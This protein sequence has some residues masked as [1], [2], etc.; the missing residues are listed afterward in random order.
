MIAFRDLPIKRKL[1]LIIML[2]IFVAL[3]CAFGAFVAYDSYTFRDALT[4]ELAGQAKELADNAV[5][6]AAANDTE[7][8]QLALNAVR[9]AAN[10]DSAC[11]YSQESRILAR[12]PRS[13]PDVA[14]PI[15]P[16]NIREYYDEYYFF[17]LQPI[18]RDQVRIGYVCL[19]ANYAAKVLARREQYIQIIVVVMLISSLVGFLVSSKLQGLIS[20]PIRELAFTARTISDKKDFSVRAVKRSGDEVG[21]LIDAFNT[22]LADI[23]ARDEQLRVSNEQ[24]EE[25]NRTLEQKVQKRTTE[26]ATAMQ[27]AESA[28]KAAEVANQTKS[29]F[30]A[31]MSHELRTPMNAI[32]GYSEML[33]EEAQDLGEESF[34][35]DLKKVHSAGTHLLGL[36][37]D[38]LDISKIESGKMEVYL[39]TFDVAQMIR[40]VASTVQPLLEKNTNTLKVECPSTIGT[41]H[42]DGTKI[43][44]GLFNLLSNACKFTDR[45]TITL[46]VARDTVEEKGWI[47]F[48]VSD[49]G[50]GLTPEQI[51]RLFQAFTQADAGTTKKYGGT[52]L[53][54]VI[55]RRFCQMMGG[56][57][58]VESEY[59]KGSTFV[60][61]IPCDVVTS[62]PEEPAVAAK[63]AEMAAELP[64]GATRILVI[65]DDPTVHDLMRRFLRKEG[66]RVETAL[67]GKEGLRMAR[68]FRP[69]AIT[70]DVMMPDMDGWSVL[71]ALKA[72]SELAG[73]PVIMLSMIDDKNMGFAL[74]ASDY[75]TKPIH[76]EQ[77]ASVLNK[78][79]HGTSTQP[80]LLVDDDPGVRRLMRSM[81]EMDGWQVI[82][83]VD[84][85]EGLA[86][87]MEARPAVVLLD[88]MMPVMDGFEFLVEAQKIKACQDV[89][90]IVVTAKDLTAEEQQRLNGNVEKILQKGAFN[91]DGLLKDVRNLV[92]AQV[93]PAKQK[94]G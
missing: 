93:S 10:I 50:I 2:T 5:A 91:R 92:V 67:G 58:T 76:R 64:A 33:M 3:V 73:I 4:R 63:L 8:S 32:I 35:A 87:M 90:I 17:V 40:E 47:S 44:Q 43:R 94:P 31:N 80:V 85:R 48:R 59:G 13:R 29:A 70:L 41:I 57:A 82:E 60:L 9:D 45:G 27:E 14:F 37:N 65:D 86:R 38:V 6:A 16:W 39:E 89:P 23:Q 56:D 55:T 42:A 62:K 1:T 22:M 61:R 24:L 21:V 12:Y 75:M 46:S 52:G 28:Q 49:T 34:S 30:L 51:G 15:D 74:G 83:A 68:E 20:D 7:A 79:R 84:G 36:I 77:M 88:L 25:S 69:D 66:F 81:L 19:K 54:L 18:L 71:S 26:L 53:G 11:V 78:Y 72:D